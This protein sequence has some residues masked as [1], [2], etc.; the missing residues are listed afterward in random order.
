MNAIAEQS[1]SRAS[2]G[3]ARLQG[4]PREVSA[5]IVAAVEDWPA[6]RTVIDE[7]VRLAARVAAPLVFVYVRRRPA[8]F[9]GAPVYQRRLT[10]AMARASR[11]LERALRAAARA[12]VRAEGEIL[13]GSPRKRIIE[14]AEDRGACLIVVGSRRRRLERR[15]SCAVVS[16]ADRPGIRVP[17]NESR[18]TAGNDDLAAPSRGATPVNPPR[19]DPVQ[20]SAAALLGPD[21]PLARGETLRGDLWRQSVVTAAAVFAGAVGT[22]TGRGWG[23]LLLV[24]AATVQL[25]LAIGLTLHAQL[26]RE[27]ARE[28]IIAGR[29][30]LAPPVLHREQRRLNRSRRR[31]SLARALDDVVRTAERRPTVVPR[32]RPIVDPG[33]ARAAAAQLRTIAARLRANAVNA[34][35]VARVERLLT[36]GASPLYGRERDELLRELKRIEADIDTAASS[37]S[38]SSQKGARPAS[39]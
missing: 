7:A 14:F 5:P 16:A 37:D 18:R 2:L 9:L 25:G 8:S 38:S 6:S 20:G 10:K 39:E 29:T 33:Q 1:S 4:E 15:V 23:L 21:H 34:P 11:T 35:A 26:Q 24:A 28:L 13:E 12:A 36:S 17:P 30:D 32:S 19:R 27:R 31:R 22:A 3:V